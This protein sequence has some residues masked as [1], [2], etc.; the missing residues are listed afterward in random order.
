MSKKGKLIYCKRCKRQFYAPSY[1]INKRIFC[2]RDCSNKFNAS[3]LSKSRIGH[4]NPMYNR[5]P[6]NYIDGR[7]GKRYPT[8]KYWIWRRKVF[9]RDKNTCQHCKIIF[10]RK[11]LIAHHIK[12]WKKYPKLRYIVNNGLTLCR[13]CHNK[14]DKEIKRTQF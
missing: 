13:P 4:N 5:K 8:T 7:G 9:N 12:S 6:W 3:H 1:Y 11:F 14:I 10:S 2:S